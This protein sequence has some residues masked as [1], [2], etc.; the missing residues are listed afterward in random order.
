MR[1]VEGEEEGEVALEVG[2]CWAP[3]QELAWGV[4]MVALEIEHVHGV[5]P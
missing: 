4:R 2:V 3:C 1:V 5:G